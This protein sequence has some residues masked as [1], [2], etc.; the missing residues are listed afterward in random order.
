VQIVGYETA[1]SDDDQPALLIA[2]EGTVRTEQLSGGTELSYQ[3][4]RRHCAGTFDYETAIHTACDREAVPYCDRHTSRW[5]CARCTGDCDLPLESCREE[6]A[7]Y[8]AAFAP[9]TFKVGVTRSW[10]LETRL[11]EQGADRAAHLRTVEDGRIARR[12]EAEIATDIGDRVR[13]EHKREGLHRTVDTEQWESL[14]AEY[15]P[16]ETFAFDYGLDLATQPMGEQLAAGTVRGAQGRLL[17]L[18][19]E[20][21]VYA[22]DLRELVG[23]ELEDGDTDRA[24]QSS[25]AAFE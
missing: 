19:R 10:R 5:A 4:G 12:I 16:L 9:V 13:V 2:E 21:T 23:Y 1:A 20:G 14:L 17:V 24:L 22:V 25:F 18:E 15:E 7:L 3:L 8:L 6:H 11:R